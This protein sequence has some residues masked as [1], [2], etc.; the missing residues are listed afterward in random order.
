MSV[1]QS[2]GMIY[3]ANISNSTNDTVIT[4][5]ASGDSITNTGQPVTINAGDGNNTITSDHRNSKHASDNDATLSN[6]VYITSGSG[7]DS[8]Y[9]NASRMN[10]FLDSALIYTPYSGYINV[11]GGDDTIRNYQVNNSEMLGGDG[12]DDIRISDAINSTVYGDTGNDYI[13][14]AGSYDTTIYGG[15]DNDTVYAHNIDG[16][17]DAGTKLIHHVHIYGGAGRDSIVTNSVNCAVVYGG[18]DDDYILGTGELNGG[19]GND[20]IS[21]NSDAATIVG[22]AGNDL[23]SLTG[24]RHLLKYGTNH[25]KDTVYGYNNSDS[26]QIAGGYS[27]AV[28][29][30]N[31]IISVGSG[32]I[33]LV[34]AKNFRINISTVE[35]GA[36]TTPADGDD[37]LGV[38]FN[39]KKPTTITITDSFTGTVDAAKFSDKVTSIDASKATQPVMLKAGS[40]STVL[41]AGSGG[42]TLLGGKADDKLY[43]GSGVDLFAY[44]LGNGKD[45]LNSVEAQDIVSIDGAS[46]DQFTFK[47]SKAA[48]TIDLGDKNSKLTVNKTNANNTITFDIDGEEF[49]YGSIPGGASLNSAKTTLTLSSEVADGTTINANVIAS[50]IKELDASKSNGSIELLGNANANVLRASKDGSTMDGGLGNDKLY[51]GSGSD[52]FV[53]SIGGGADVVYNFDGRQGD[54]VVLE[55]V[56]SLDSKTVKVSATKVD[57]TV[58]KGK[59]S[60]DNPNGEMKFFDASGNPSGVGYNKNKTAITIDSSAADVGTIDLNEPKYFSTVKEIDA[61]LY[62]GAIEMIGNAQANIFRAGSGSST[63]NGGLGNDKLYGGSDAD[64]FKYSVGGGNDVIYGFDGTKG[65]YVIL[66]GIDKLDS[67]AF[68]ASATKVEVK[69]GTGKLTFDN[70]NGE[71][72]AKNSIQWA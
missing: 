37:T 27:T 1:F 14:N 30:N 40:K 52:V 23:I 64:V 8:V 47:D 31:V 67:S 12:N 39:A 28:S 4:G 11:G 54:Y 45:V 71:I 72:P 25:G 2:K 32:S 38:E 59:L 58:G 7:K 65:D 21:I 9:V 24:S 26:L 16:F 10:G 61:S 70:P 57:V 44:T 63:M 15:D 55:G 19:A 43:G 66:E 36:D 20:T 41:R 29:G 48:V 33:T 62:G 49:V 22:G 69:I 60:F 3:M 34:N 46:L 51:G 68:K 13:E 6:R 42:S 56:T 53:Y 17:N 50:T 5:T 18:E 35:G